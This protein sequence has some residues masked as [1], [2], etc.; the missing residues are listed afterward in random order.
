MANEYIDKHQDEFHEVKK[1]IDKNLKKGEHPNYLGKYI[2]CVLQTQELMVANAVIGHLATSD[3]CL[4]TSVHGKFYNV[5]EQHDG[6][7]LS[8]ESI[9]KW[10]EGRGWT[11]DRAAQEIPNYLDLISMKVLGQ[12]CAKWEI[13]EMKTGYLV[14]ATVLD[15]FVPNNRVLAFFDKFLAKFN[16]NRRSKS[17]VEFLAETAHLPSTYKFVTLDYLKQ[18]Y[19]DIDIPGVPLGKVPHIT[20]WL[21]HPKKRKFDE[22]YEIIPTKADP[23][24]YHG[25]VFNTWKNFPY[26]DTWETLREE[27]E[28]KEFLQ[29][30]ERLALAVTGGDEENRAKL[31]RLMAHMLQRP[32]ELGVVI[33]FYGE[34][35]GTGKSTMCEVA[36]ALVGDYNSTV[37]NDI[38]KELCGDFNTKL[39]N[40][41]VVV[42]EGKEVKDTGA[43]NKVKSM[44]T[45]KTVSINRKFCDNYDVTNR[46]RVMW[47]TNSCDQLPIGYTNRRLVQFTCSPMLMRDKIFFK[48]FYSKLNDKNAMNTIMKFLMNYELADDYKPDDDVPQ[49]TDEQKE[50]TG[51][52]YF[53]F[54]RWLMCRMSEPITGKEDDMPNFK[55]TGK[56]I[57]DWFVEFRNENNYSESPTL[58]QLINRVKNKLESLCRSHGLDPKKYVSTEI[59]SRQNRITVYRW[60]LW[61]IAEKSF[62]ELVRKH[63]PEKKDGLCVSSFTLT[64]DG[65][66]D[67]Q[68]SGHGEGSFEEVVAHIPTEVH[69]PFGE[70]GGTETASAG[71]VEGVQDKGAGDG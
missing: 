1:I 30:F 32:N 65:G 71:A 57:L 27:D 11:T 10:G 25:N 43:W 17:F 31:F 16:G 18:T 60:N 2:A 56:E 63:E 38:Q 41:L 48:R 61:R 6:I 14:P 7:Q 34:E 12:E 40:F 37:T 68:Y 54:I 19:N 36:R 15:S 46:L 21:N 62:P 58:F 70:G 26:W 4:I 52:M 28:D 33:M 3:A 35:E 39:E 8:K 20:T 66:T 53:R 51:D 67:R 55:H 24:P 9:R 5:I 42:Q 64:N 44:I 13:K 22:V 23:C 50:H 47:T 49:L 45:D 69:E 59:M 29:D